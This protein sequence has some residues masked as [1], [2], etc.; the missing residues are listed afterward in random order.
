MA[1]PAR[2]RAA[3]RISRLFICIALAALPGRVMA[4]PRA[5]L[6][7][8]GNATC[9]R[10]SGHRTHAAVAIRVAGHPLA[11]VGGRSWHAEVPL[12]TAREWANASG[13]MLALTLIDPRAQT[14]TVDAVAVPP[15]ALGR[16]IELAS[17]VVSA[18]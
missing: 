9:L 18:H 10:L 3:A 8:C 14:E 11:V 4:S 17:L 6:V 13:E 2:S 16:R 7:Y 12:D 1:I 5:L 15:G